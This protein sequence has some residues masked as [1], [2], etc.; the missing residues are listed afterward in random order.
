MEWT[1]MIG[2]DNGSLE[3]VAHLFS[4]SVDTC[5]DLSLN[6]T[7]MGEFFKELLILLFHHAA[8]F[9]RWFW[10]SGGKQTPLSG[11]DQHVGVTRTDG[12]RRW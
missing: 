2:S 6:L 12:T 5:L 11:V 1:L 4:V 8:Q 7:L 9:G 10:R 3:K